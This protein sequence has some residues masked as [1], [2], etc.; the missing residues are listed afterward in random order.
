M[1]VFLKTTHLS[2]ILETSEKSKVIIFKYSN[3]CK[4]S[5]DLEQEFS[6][7]L[8]Q[9]HDLKIFQVTVQIEKELSRKIEEWFQIR[10]ETPQIIVIERGKVLHESH[11]HTINL[12]DI[13]SLYGGR[14]REQNKKQI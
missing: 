2:E 1:I 3:N 7:L 9:K 6:K 8:P 13:I 5:S 12:R 10:H 4:S 11:H 14:Q